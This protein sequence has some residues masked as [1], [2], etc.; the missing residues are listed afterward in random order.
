MD[1]RAFDALAK[2]LSARLPRRSALGLLAALGLVAEAAEAG[3]AAGGRDGGKEHGRNRG[4]RPGKGKDHRKGKHRKNGAGSQICP[5]LNAHCTSRNECCRE[6][7][8]AWDCVP[9]NLDHS[10]QLPCATDKDCLIASLAYATHCV[11]DAVA[12]PT[13]ERCCSIRA[14]FLDGDCPAGAKCLN[15][16]CMY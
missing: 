10:C 15:F 2:T 8:G 3:N 9:G 11:P 1:D 5:L 7:A 6:M 4:H 14:C 13:L 12:C 16:R